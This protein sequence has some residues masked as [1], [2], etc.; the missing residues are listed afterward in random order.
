MQELVK[1]FVKRAVK[2]TDCK[3][4]DQATGELRPGKYYRSPLEYETPVYG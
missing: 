4:V 1:T 3:W 2:G